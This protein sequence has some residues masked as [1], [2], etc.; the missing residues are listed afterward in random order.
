MTSWE[1]RRQQQP[2]PAQKA[3]HGGREAKKQQARN[4]IMKGDKLGRQGGSGSQEQPRME[5]MKGDK[6]GFQSGSGS[7]EAANST[8]KGSK[9]EVI[10]FNQSEVI[11]TTGTFLKL[12][13][14][15]IKTWDL[16]VNDLIATTM[17]LR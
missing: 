11:R 4:E 14:S 13:Q 16:F 17:V 5:I 15:L 3:N 10:S 9:A 2:R 8:R 7:Q 6:L 1:T 12:K